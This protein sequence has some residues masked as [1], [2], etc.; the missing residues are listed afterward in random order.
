MPILGAYPYLLL[1]NYRH[2]HKAI[3]WMCNYYKTDVLGLYAAHFP[4]IVANTTASAK[5]CLNNPALDGKPALK[6]AQLR[7]PNFDVRGNVFTQRMNVE[8]FVT[9]WF[10]PFKY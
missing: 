4:T 5:E 1:V 2:L 7:D 6:L 3:D 9:W 10:F 8:I